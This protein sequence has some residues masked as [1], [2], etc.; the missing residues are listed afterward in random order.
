MAKCFHNM[1]A[2]MN[3]L[4]KTKDAAKMLGVSHQFLERDRWLNPNNPRVP[5]VRVGSRSVRYSL[6]DLEEYVKAH[7]LQNKTACQGAK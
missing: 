3:D 1:E 5:Y 2:K 4:L 7:T 6:H